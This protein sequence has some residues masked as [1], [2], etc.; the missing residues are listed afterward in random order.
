M[1]DQYDIIIIGAGPAGMAAAAT[2]AEIGGTEVSVLVLDE[3]PAPGGQIYR[4]IE[5]PG[6]AAAV[7]GTEY[8]A[9]AALAQGLRRASGDDGPIDYASD[10]T[11]WQVDNTGR[12]GVSIDG[13]A[14]LIEGRT[15]IIATGAVE[16]PFPIPGWTLPGVM[17]AGAAQ[18]MLK[19]A[20]LAAEGAVFAGTGPLLYLIVAQYLRAGVDVR[21]ILDTTPREQY[22]R[23]AWLLPKAWFAGDHIKRG[24][25]YM[26]EI[27]R[28][29][30]QHIKG[31]TELRVDAA[32]IDDPS[33][34]IVT[35]RTRSGGGGTMETPHVFLHQ[36]VAPNV[37]LSRAAG[38]EH[39]WDA[40]QHCWLVVS[41]EWGETSEPVIF[42]AGDGGR[43]A[44][45]I[46]AECRGR[47]AALGALTGLG[48]IDAGMRDAQAQDARGYLAREL[49]VR[50]FLDLLYAP[51]TNFRVPKDDAT[52]VCRC[53]EI[54]AG[55]VRRAVADGCVGPNQLK[56]FCRAGMG[57]CQGRQCALTVTE[58]IAQETDRDPHDVGD[59]RRRPPVKP[60]KLSELADLHATTGYSE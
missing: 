39:A 23:A 55:E 48:H 30:V 10:A 41:D 31:V 7:L 25:A 60:L 34:K 45:A 57:P 24:L 28:A 9:G 2:L 32:S 15:I 17:T 52:I 36:G 1:K 22:R 47:M 43:I 13:K 33:A 29:G 40:W 58:I 56:A 5:S 54:T 59:Y 19:S 51:A 35:Y 27:K 42:V 12:V 11:V 16:R 38:L 8:A 46:A 3:Q 21:A 44:G 49:V 6:R 50:P 20:D 14:R 53:E 18:I 37:N 26:K 4:G